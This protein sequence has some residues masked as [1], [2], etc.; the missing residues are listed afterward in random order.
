MSSVIVTGGAGYIGSHTCKALSLAGFDPVVY[1]SLQ[2]G[3]AW[4]VK[5]GPFEEGDL[6]DTDRIRSVLQKYQPV[7]VIHFAAFA[8][9]G[10][11]V[12][13]PLK[14]YHNNVGGT[15]SLLRAMAIEGVKRLVFSSTCATY[16]TPEVNPIREDLEQKPINPYGQ[17]KLM[18][19]HIL[20]DCARNSTLSAVALRYFNAAGADQEG[21]I[22]EAH[23][24]ETHIIPLALSAARGGSPPLVVFGDDHPTPDGTCIRDYVHVMDLADAHVKAL[25]HT[26]EKQGFSAFNLGTGAGVSIME[27]INT[28]R[29][30]TGCEVPYSFGSKRVGDPPA[31]VAD[32]RKA[33]EILGWK[34]EHSDLK[35]ILQTAW[36]WMEHR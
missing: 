1:D 26:S 19:E 4:A 14:Y 3:N 25:A 7:G 35:N 13:K 27:L 10:E 36:N 9:V 24:P 18:V 32:P 11:S 23:D 31:L 15:M 34:A 2:R 8:Y 17:S 28:V 20:E 29:E 30:V 21:E 12:H 33:R 6:L 5:W 22:G 16:G